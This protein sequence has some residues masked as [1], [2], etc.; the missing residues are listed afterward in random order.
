M[1]T[2]YVAAGEPEREALAT[3]IKNLPGAV[4]TGTSVNLREALDECATEAPGCLVVQDGLLVE[5]V[6]LLDQLGQ[7]PYPI[8]LIGP[9]TPAT[10]RRALTIR[11]RDLL[12]QISWRDQLEACLTRY[13]IPLKGPAP[14]PGKVIVVF[15][16]KGGVGKTTIAVNLAFALDRASKEPV[17]LLDLDLQFGDVAP[18]VGEIPNATIHDLVTDPSNLIDS[19]RMER[20]M[21]RVGNTGVEVLAAPAKPEDAEDVRA[22]HVVRVLQ[23]LRHTHAFVVVD[24]APGYSEVNVAALDFADE[25][26]V[27]CTP[28]VMTVRKIGQALRLFY[29]GFRYPLQKVKIVLNR[30]GSR[31]GV[32]VVDIV[33]TL[34]HDV[35]YQLA[36]DGSWPVKAANQGRPLQLLQPE[37]LLSRGLRDIARQLVEE[38]QGPSRSV[39]HV[40]PRHR[41]FP[42]LGTPHSS[43]RKGRS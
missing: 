39:R 19:H 10:A 21:T 38:I 3:W 17:A 2:V 28:D 16:P 5:N 1:Y 30:A 8:V 14:T 13:A 6:G 40:E 22:D 15:S 24:S 26:L 34:S 11:A 7:A 25:V 42:R 31:T 4:L 23:I 9:E 35:A 29:E 20:V 41:W 43:E 32:E 27:I 12:P 18:M 37:S 33:R 36:S